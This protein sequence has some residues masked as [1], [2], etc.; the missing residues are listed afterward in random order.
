M[1]G[2]EPGLRLRLRRSAAR[3]QATVVVNDVHSTRLDSTIAQACRV[4][5]AQ[6]RRS[7]RF[8]LRYNLEASSGTAWTTHNGQQVGLQNARGTDDVHWGQHDKYSC[9]RSGRSN[10]DALENIKPSERRRDEGARDLRVPVHL[11]HVA[12]ALVHKQQLWWHFA[13]TALRRLCR[14]LLVI[15]LN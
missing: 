1:N 13:V 9:R 15:Q 8:H 3:C 12:L 6:R 14:L 5:R 10:R 7:G 11:L 4:S 2:R